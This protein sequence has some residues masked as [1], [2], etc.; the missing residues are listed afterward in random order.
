MAWENRK[1]RVY[2]YRGRRVDGRLV[3][4]YYGKG[5]LAEMIAGQVEAGHAQ[6]AAWQARKRREQ[7]VEARVRQFDS[8]CDTMLHAAMATAGIFYHRGEWRRKRDFQEH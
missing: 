6:R 4:K 5:I 3:K 7:A 8:M 2:Y 1:G